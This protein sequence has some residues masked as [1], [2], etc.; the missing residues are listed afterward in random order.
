MTAEQLFF[1]RLN[2]QLAERI[3]QNILSGA[4]K[5]G[6]KLSTE[7]NLAEDYGVGRAVVGEAVK[8]LK[9]EGLIEIKA[10]LGT[11]DVDG[12][13]REFSH[14]LGLLKRGQMHHKRILEA[15]RRGDADAAQFAMQAHLQQ[16]RH[17][18]EVSPT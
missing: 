5:L 14:S 18:S 2:E 8:A 7:R 15:I 10:G 9:Q 1:P 16:V 13:G 17:D 12:A 3:R 11:F 4:L 6:E